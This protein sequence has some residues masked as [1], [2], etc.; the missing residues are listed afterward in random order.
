MSVCVC[1][2]VCVCLG[3]EGSLCKKNRVLLWSHT[4]LIVEGVVPDLLHVIPVGNDAML[5]G[6]LQRKDA[7]LALSL[8]SHVGVLL[9]HAHHDTLVPR[10]AHDGGEDSPGSIVAR[11]PG[12]AHARAIVNHEGG[13]FFVTHD[14]DGYGLE[15]RI[16]GNSSA[17]NADL[18][19]NAPC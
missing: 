19:E 8:I 18:F 11:K 1:V 5:D 12:L 7:P 3:V 15:G 13:N 2:W 9:A 14:E 17:P 4:E 16:R 10:A 6:V